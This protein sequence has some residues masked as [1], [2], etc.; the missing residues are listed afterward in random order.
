[1]PPRIEIFRKHFSV[2][3]DNLLL[4]PKG[5]RKDR[6]YPLVT[7]LHGMGM[8]A[9]EFARLLAPVA[10]LPLLLSVPEGVYP[11]EIRTGDS[12]RIGRAWYLY[13]GDQRE[14]VES[15]RVSGRHLCALD[16]RI[17]KVHRV[18]PDRRVLLG[19]SQG[20]YFAGY[21][22]IRTAS[23]RRGSLRKGSRL[24]GLVVVGARVKTEVLGPRLR[25]AK[26][27]SVLLSHGRKDRAVPFTA[28]E[29]SR[30][31]LTAAGLEVDLREYPGGHHFTTDQVLDAKEWLRK[32]FGLR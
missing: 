19:F 30:D 29:E 27:L 15:M 14:F 22:G 24:R 4:V 20:G 31:A 8:N 2:P 17:E 11:F 13:T 25:R 1:M 26:G 5:Y 21:H 28:A 10:E 23:L 7:A 32:L 6:R 3:T 18:D 12:M 16:A 9:E